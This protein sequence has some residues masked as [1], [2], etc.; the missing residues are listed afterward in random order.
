MNKAVLLFASSLFLLSCKEKES[1][2]KSA[3]E[4]SAQIIIEKSTAG[5]PH[6]QYTDVALSDESIAAF[7]KDLFAALE[8][9]DLSKIF[10]FFYSGGD[11]D[12]NSRG[13]DSVE[14]SYNF[15]LD[16]TANGLQR[17]KGFLEENLN[18]GGFLDSSTWG[19]TFFVAPYT[20]VL[21]NTMKDSCKEYKLHCGIVQGEAVDVFASP[22]LNAKVVQRLTE[23][24]VVRVRKDT[25]CDPAGLNCEWRKVARFDGTQGFSPI[26][27]IRT[28][29]D[30]SIFIQKIKGEWKIVKIAG[31]SVR[32]PPEDSEE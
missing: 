19:D 8:K 13:I 1:G 15:N 22:A 4:T 2:I 3:P 6:V 26:K 12:I 7:K 16:G 5:I 29:Y 24:E 10:G 32:L 20:H 31:T 27:K 11:P 9:N 17:L 30:G 14:L 23:N 18:L 21:A 25:L 28:Q